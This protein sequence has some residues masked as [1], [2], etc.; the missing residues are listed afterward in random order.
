[1]WNQHHREQKRWDRSNRPNTIFIPCTVP[2]NPTHFWKR[3]KIESAAVTSHGSW[4]GGGQAC[5]RDLWL[6]AVAKQKWESGLLMWQLMSPCSDKWLLYNFISC[7]SPAKSQCIS[8]AQHLWVR[9][10]DRNDFEAWKSPID[11]FWTTVQLKRRLK[12]DPSVS[13]DGCVLFVFQIFQVIQAVDNRDARH[14]IHGC[15]WNARFEF[16]PGPQPSQEL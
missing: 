6:G 5:N 1:M 13:I 12:Y 7:W 4:L 16:D 10:E 15:P 9:F 14:Q 8:T 2:R 3:C 11:C